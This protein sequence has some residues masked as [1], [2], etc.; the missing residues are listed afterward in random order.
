MDGKTIAEDLQRRDFTINA[1]AYELASDKFIDNLGGQQDLSR[2]V[3]RMLSPR[4]FVSD[5]VRLLRAYRLAAGLDFTIESQTQ[6][7]IGRHADLIQKSAGERIKD[8]LFK[9]LQSDTSYP[10]VLEMADSGLFVQLFPEFLETPKDPVDPS[11]CRPALKDTFAAYGRLEELLKDPAKTLP[12]TL[13]PYYQNLSDTVKALLKF[14]ILWH[15]IG[16]LALEGQNAD[17]STD[18]S[19]AVNPA[20]SAQMAQ[21]LCKR[22]RF[23]NRHTE[24]INLI[25]ENQT[26]PFSLF[27]AYQ[28]N[29]VTVKETTRLF[30]KCRAQTPA[31]ML[32]A[33]ADMYGRQGKNSARGR[34]FLEFVIHL[35]QDRYTAFEAK[36][37]LPPL[38]SG[39]DLIDEFELAPSPLFKRILRVVEEKRLSGKTR[40]RSD[41]LQM[42]KNFLAEHDRIP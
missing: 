20:R 37:A 33:L 23:A 16:G 8:E 10:S 14:C 13:E 34:A 1:M 24:Y 15:D 40:T 3:I 5:P 39:R 25:I 22:Y 42:V 2:K 9:M 17:P 30:M 32:H 7:A 26:R 41:A 27:S 19:P 11:R 12:P 36:A 29:T 31:L 18:V 38:I 21:R 35:L 4:A 28:S 6:S